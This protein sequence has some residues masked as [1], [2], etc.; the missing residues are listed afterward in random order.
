MSFSLSGPAN[1][2]LSKAIDS[3]IL[4]HHSISWSTSSYPYPHRLW[5]N[6]NI[7]LFCF[8]NC[9][10]DSISS[11]HLNT[12]VS[13]VVPWSGDTVGVSLLLFSFLPLVVFA[14]GASIFIPSWF[15]YLFVLCV[16]SSLLPMQKSHK[17]TGYIKIICIC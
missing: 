15:L 4:I 13:P 1:P 5:N 14:G 11:H 8:K 16:R 17:L 12:A 10:C 3:I 7:S 6:S 9:D 2:W